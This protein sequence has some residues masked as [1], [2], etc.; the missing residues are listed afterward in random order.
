MAAAVVVVDFSGPARA[1]AVEAALGWCRLHLAFKC[2][3]HLAFLSHHSKLLLPPSPAPSLS[4]VCHPVPLDNVPMSLLI[5][6]RT[7]C[8]STVQ[9]NKVLQHRA[10]N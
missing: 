7:V 2:P 10:D 5:P 6:L 4:E 3:P 1:G 8:D 9:A